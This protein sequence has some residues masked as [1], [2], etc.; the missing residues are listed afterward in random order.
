MEIGFE[1]INPMTFF[2]SGDIT[3]SNKLLELLYIFIGLGALYK[4]LS[5]FKDKENPKALGTGFFWTLLAVIMIVGK[6]IP[7]VCSGI[8]VVLMTLPPILKR[9]APG[10]GKKP[11]PEY[12][13]EMAKKISFKIFIPAFTI[14]VCAVIFAIF[15]T[16]S[17]LVGVGLGVI[18]A[19]IMLMVMSKDNK[20][21]VFLKD[22]SRMLGVVG[23]L[24]MLP[25][26]LAALGAVFNEAGVGTSIG[27][28]LGNIVPEGNMTVGIII[29]AVGM[30]VFTM[31]M[32]N[33]FAAITVMT[34]GI[35]APF[36]LAY[37]ANPALIVMIGLTC[38]YCGT[39]LTPMAANFNIVPVAILEMKSK[40][41]V[42][43]YQIFPALFMLVVQ[44]VYMIAF[45]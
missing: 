36:V 27:K 20:P 13:A 33:A 32:G 43:K 18:L 26:L 40:Y 42:I 4:G 14:G 15:T 10:S 2:T 25:M 6:W 21:D 8:L 39:L 24:S 30:V 19:I 7:P 22:Q 34:T 9:V 37:G 16:I 23:P 5:S 12:T 1:F 11:S 17:P 31:I 45:A 3:L 28:I 38:G 44:I 29:Y 35:A 41:S